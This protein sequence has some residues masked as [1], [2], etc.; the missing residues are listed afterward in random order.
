MAGQAKDSASSPNPL[1]KV[2]EEA[3]N[4]SEARTY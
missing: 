3:V 1:V 2:Y 4:E